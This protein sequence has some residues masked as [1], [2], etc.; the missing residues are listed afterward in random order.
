MPTQR[1]APPAP[2]V[3][4][5]RWS[6]VWRRRAVSRDDEPSSA[7]DEL[8]PETLNRRLPTTV[9]NPAATVHIHRRRTIVWRRRAVSRDDEPSSADD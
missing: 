4:R 9:C 1:K 5:R 2:A 6:I 8:H 3:I 7:D